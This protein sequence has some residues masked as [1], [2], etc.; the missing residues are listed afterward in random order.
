MLRT[1]DLHAHTTAS[2]GDHAPTALIEAAAKIGLT[3]LAVTD[4][5]TTDGIAEAQRAGRRLGVEVVPGI[6]L[7]AEFPKGQCH[8]LGLRIDPA[9]EPLNLRLREVVQNRNARNAQIVEKMQKDGLDITLADVEAIA[10][11]TGPR[12]IVARPHFAAALIQKGVV[13]SVPEAFE[14][15]LAKGKPYYA[16]RD[17]LTP[18]EAFGLIHAA[19]G[20]A[21]LAHPNNLNR[22]AAET[23]AEIRRFQS[24]GMDGIE[25]RYNRHAPED[26]ARYLEL[27]ARRGLLTSGGSDFHGPSVKPTVLLGHVEG[28]LPAPAELLNA[29]KTGAA[30][31]R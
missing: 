13:A 9:S 3:A 15:F 25:A 4:H 28:E 29:L 21:I 18:Q 6:E 14:R 8:V 27:A 1:I 7:S 11:G 24:L 30:Q 12:T 20:V 10:G 22:D 5:D 26:N 31:Y 23:E 16:E 17:R 2:D 19:G